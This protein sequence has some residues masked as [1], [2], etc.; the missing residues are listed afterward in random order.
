MIPAYE[1]NPGTVIITEKMV[2]RNVTSNSFSI[3]DKLLFIQIHCVFTYCRGAPFHL[4]TL[5]I[6]EKVKG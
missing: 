4:K 6:L 3:N 5:Y 2:V 1:E